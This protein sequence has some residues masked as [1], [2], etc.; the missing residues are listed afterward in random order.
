MRPIPDDAAAELEVV[1]TPDLT[2]QFERL[3]PVHPVYATYRMAQH[4]EEAGRMLLLPALED[5]EEAAGTAVSVEHL[6]PASVGTRVRIEA[7]CAAVEG[8]CE[9]R[10]HVEAV[11][12]AGYSDHSANSWSEVATQTLTP[13]SRA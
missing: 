13:S 5:G 2:V 8:V 1:V 4:F 11:S 12:V 9:R 10:R 3:G 7:R 6:A